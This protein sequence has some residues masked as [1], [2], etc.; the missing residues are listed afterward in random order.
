MFQEQNRH[1]LRSWLHEKLIVEKFNNWFGF[2]ILLCVALFV[3]YLAA[4][5][6][7][8]LS[9]ITLLA[10]LA[11]PLAAI[12]IYSVKLGFYA[13]LILTSF[14]PLVE[15]FFVLQINAGTYIDIFIYFL[16]V[17]VLV[18]KFNITNDWRFL[19]EP[20]TILL[21]IGFGFD[22]LQVLNPNGNF[23][24][25]FFGARLSLRF[26]CIYFIVETVF[27]KRKDV[28]LF[29]K[30]WL[31]IALLASLY[32]FY[33]EWFGLPSFDLDWATKNPQRRAQLFI[34][35]R[36]RKWSFL[37]DVANFGLFMSFAGMMAILLSLNKF[38]WYKR[39]V[40]IILGVTFWVAMMYSGTRTAYA[41][42][43]I[44]VAMY[45]LMNINKVKTLIFA[46]VT[47]M[48]FIFIYFAPIYNPTLTRL[49]SAFN[50]EEDASMN[51]RDV[52][53]ARIQP[54]IWSHPFGGG[55][56]TT[57][58]PGE[59]HI[60]YHPL[61]GFPPDSGYLETLLEAGW[62]GL[63]L[64]MAI[65]VAVL[66]TGLK[67]YYDIRDPILK[68]YYLAFIAS[69]FALTIALYAKLGIDGFP[70]VLVTMTNYV[71]MFRLK[72]FDREPVP[73]LEAE[74]D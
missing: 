12:C 9:I 58:T 60:P 2:T 68:G 63:L 30:V 18:R 40:L 64:E 27:Q 26:V 22:L 71:L 50:P 67:N 35:G 47:G 49:R 42:I 24:A 6:G 48:I 62:F 19:R 34:A 57:G 45:F 61:A 65:F 20:I 13:L 59:E 23:T 55:L 72:K 21:L 32:A 52:N 46:V 54:Y 51:V 36:F 16:M 33:Q 31:V 29:L 70:M 66:G 4:S 3:T 25:W 7:L 43:P 38:L 39:I 11:I 41:I 5:G 10:I 15:R 37:S 73:A 44:G 56:M 74:E 8:N 28:F 53:R 69:F 1:S 14:M 17:I